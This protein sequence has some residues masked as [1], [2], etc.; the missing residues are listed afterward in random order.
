MTKTPTKLILILLCGSAPFWACT[1][2]DQSGDR[3]NA[4]EDSPPPPDAEEPPMEPPPPPPEPEPVCAGD[5]PPT[6]AQLDEAKDKLQKYLKKCRGQAAVDKVLGEFDKNK[7]DALSSG[8]LL[9]LIKRIG[10]GYPFWYQDWCDGVM[11]A[12]DKTPKDGKASEQELLDFLDQIGL[13][14]TA[15]CGEDTP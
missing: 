13:G 10:L 5:K 9:A 11:P 6:Q 4:L 1:V 14:G 2:P 15:Q 3:A 8:E 7:D 12:I